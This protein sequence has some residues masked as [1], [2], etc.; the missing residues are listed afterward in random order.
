MGNNSS[1]T[2][3]SKSKMKISKSFNTKLKTNNAAVIPKGS[4]ILTT[5]THPFED[6]YTLIK[7]IGEGMNGK[8]YLCQNKKDK[9][10][11]ALKVC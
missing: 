9:K 11:Y 10:K 3:E 1:G 2:K 7:V 5:K 6:D 8:V 4:S